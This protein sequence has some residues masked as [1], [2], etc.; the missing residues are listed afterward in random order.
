MEFRV[1]TVPAVQAD[2]GAK[3]LYRRQLA[4]RHM[5][6]DEDDTRSIEITHRTCD[7]RTVVP[8]GRDDHAALA[9][10]LVER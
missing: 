8:A 10:C 9:R 2:V 1:E 3:L 6:R 7:G 4:L 5:L